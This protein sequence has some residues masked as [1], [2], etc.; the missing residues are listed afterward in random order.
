M[1]GTSKHIKHFALSDWDAHF[2]ILLITFLQSFLFEGDLEANMLQV[3]QDAVSELLQ[4]LPD[5]S[6]FVKWLIMAYHFISV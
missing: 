5:P 6:T 2:D 3:G 4:C 1:S